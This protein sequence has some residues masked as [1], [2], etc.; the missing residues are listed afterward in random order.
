VLSL[1]REINPADILPKCASDGPDKLTVLR[2][3]LA[4]ARADITAMQEELRSGFSR[5]LVAVLRERE[6]EEVSLAGQ[7]QDAL[8]ASLRPLEREWADLPGL[9][10][11]VEKGGDAARVRIKLALRRIVE[12]AQLLI[13]PRSGCTLAAM[14]FHFKGAGVRHYVVYY[15]PARNHVRGGSWCDSLATVYDPADLDLRR[16][17]HAARLERALAAVKLEAP[18]DKE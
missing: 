5:A 11:A 3:K 13:V 1:L 18:G 2:A 17:D 12:S 16:R 9:L 6:A 14:Q 15:K 7:L 8:A 4:N 10:D